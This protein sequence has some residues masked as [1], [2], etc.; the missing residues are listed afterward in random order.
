MNYS[1]A[2]FSLY[3][4]TSADKKWMIQI[5][6]NFILLNW[7]RQDDQIVGQYPGFEVVYKRFKTVLDR[8]KEKFRQA[9]GD[10][11]FYKQIKTYTLTY[12]DR[13]FWQ[14][15]IENLSSI[16]KLLN[17]SVPTIPGADNIDNISVK[18][19]LPFKEIGGYGVMSINSAIIPPSNNILIL[20]CRIKGKYEGERIDD[21]FKSANQV[22]V[23]SFENIIENNIL[24]KWKQ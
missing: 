16:N 5:Q 15:H 19:T 22:Q 18:Y 12:Q 17:L 9:Q 3:R 2:G 11:D 1:N 8:V 14:E 10:I 21:W 24:K 13:I 7:I 4:L 20:E 6:Q 23:K